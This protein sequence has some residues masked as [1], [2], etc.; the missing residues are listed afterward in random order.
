MMKSMNDVSKMGVNEVFELL[1]PMMKE[2]SIEF[3]PIATRRTL[4]LN[5]KIMHVFE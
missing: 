3:L 1:Q 5:W 2:K 4:R